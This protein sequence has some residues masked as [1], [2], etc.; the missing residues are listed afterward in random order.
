MTSPTSESDAIKSELLDRCRRLIRPIVGYR[1]S[2]STAVHSEK[3]AVCIDYDFHMETLKIFLD[4][5]PDDSGFFTRNIYS[6]E[7]GEDC[8]DM[9]VARDIAL[10]ILRRHMVLDDLA[11]A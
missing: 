4:D 6:N 7:P 3:Y 10:P 1:I 8:W 9:E 2:G 5:D 11:G